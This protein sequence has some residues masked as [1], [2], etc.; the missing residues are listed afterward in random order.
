M[1]FL[2][3]IDSK[4]S[5]FWASLLL[6]VFIIY[7]NIINLYWDIQHWKELNIIL[8]GFVIW[9]FRYVVFALLCWIL[10]NLNIY[11]MPEAKLS[12]RFFKN[13]AITA[14]AYAI[15]VLV[16]FLLCV[17]ADCF[18]SNLL[19]QFFVACLLCTT[20]GHVY[21]LNRERS[22][23]EKE[24]ELLRIENLQSRCDALA[25]QINPHFFFNSLNGLTAL[26]RGDDKEKTL[27]YISKLSSVFRYILQSDKKG[28][29][30]LAEELG[31][32]ES[33]S[34]LHQI[35]YGDKL[36]FVIDVPKEKGTWNCLSYRFCL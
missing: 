23:K 21:S 17:H 18:T 1:E 2:N 35:R 27:E 24:I 10:L 4:R 12:V 36:T 25:N 32:V 9:V 8:Q 33:Y 31:F 20:I 28:L 19:F 11:K 22:K 26:V 34:Y 30:T 5:L 15:Y 7:P 14:I 6:S 13:I 29:V 3:K 16:S